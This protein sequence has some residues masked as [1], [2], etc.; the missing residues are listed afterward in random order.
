MQTKRIT[1]YVAN[2][3]QR[4]YLDI[5]DTRN[6]H[7]NEFRARWLI[8]FQD[9]H[10]QLHA[11]LDPKYEVNEKSTTIADILKLGYV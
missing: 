7:L 4:P 3:T 8:L 6:V 5:R 10:P 11:L 1:V 2:S 9:P